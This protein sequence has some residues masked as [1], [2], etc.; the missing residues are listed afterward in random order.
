MQLR[1]GRF[2]KGIAKS[3]SL[4]PWRTF[5]S[6]TRSRAI[7]KVTRAERE[8]NRRAREALVAE[9]RP[10]FDEVFSSF[11]L[12]VDSYY[13]NQIAAGGAIGVPSGPLRSVEA[14]LAVVLGDGLERSVLEGA[15]LGIRFSGIEGISLSPDLVTEIAR[16]FA[17]DI[18]GR[19]IVQITSRIREDVQA[20]VADVLDLQLSPDTA[21]QQIGRQVGLT[22]QEAAALRRF[23][24]TLLRRRIPNELADTQLVRETIAQDVE[25]RRD[26]M[27]RNRGNRILETEVQTALQ[28]GERGFWQQAATAGEVDLN[29]LGKTWFTVAD[30]A[31]CPICEPLHGVSVGFDEL[32]SS[33]GFAGLNPPAHVRCR[34]YLDYGPREG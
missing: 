34:C 2:R 6:S 9:L 26:Q 18:G 30:G 19:R 8:A 11:R 23:E 14:D 21:A 13:R 12:E 1:P 10:L 24:N 4:L 5:K 7:A 3:S 20:I 29:T 27:I 17:E 33:S 25:A 16:R 15:E 28:E 31:V 22:R 32:F